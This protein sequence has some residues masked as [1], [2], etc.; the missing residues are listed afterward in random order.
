MKIL[1]VDATNNFIRNYA[2]VP[3]ISM[4]GDPNG[5]VLGFL[6]S[7]SSFVRVTNAD[8]IIL[9]WDG[10]GG[11]RKRQ[12]ILKDYKD[13]KKPLRLNR[14][15]DLEQDECERNKIQQ[16][17]KLAEY[18]NFLPVTQLS[19]ADVEADDVIAYLVQYFAEDEKVIASNDKDFFQLL[20]DKVVVYSPTAKEFRDVNWLY[21][22]YNIYPQNFCLARALAGDPSDSV[23]GI[24]GVGLKN[25]KSRL[26]KYFPFF[27]GKEK[28]TVEQI[29]EHSKQNDKK[30]ERFTLGE[31]VIIKN[32]QV[33]QLENPI[34]SSSS[35]RKIKEGLM[36]RCSFNA[37]AF[38][39][40]MMEDG[41]TDIS[42]SF[43]EPFRCIANRRK[44]RWS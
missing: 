39:V 13:G 23:V 12:E 19:I 25:N 20:S 24:S 8:E 34:M 18:L 44:G 17:L 43:F 15:H 21:E 32:Q 42:E 10:P 41:I 30:Y 38:R 27:T 31:Q 26:L 36:K 40:K 3:N 5:G 4:N 16:R 2:V 11:S 22:K 14:S 7:L 33:M 9:V 28:V 1:L 37:T 29:V 35:I 6:K